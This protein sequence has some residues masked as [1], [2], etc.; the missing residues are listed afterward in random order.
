MR[1]ETMP[2]TL[3]LS[4]EKLFDFIKEQSLYMALR[5]FIIRT[6]SVADVR[7]DV[8]LMY[9]LQNAGKKICFSQ[10]DIFFTTVKLSNLLSLN[11]WVCWNTCVCMI[12]ITCL[13]L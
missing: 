6:L 1:Q 8:P 3:R 4:L 7:P 11:K 10:G 5:R 12:P 9:Y 13:R 2:E